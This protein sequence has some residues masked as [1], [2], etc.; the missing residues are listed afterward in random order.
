MVSRPKRPR[1]PN[2]LAKLIVD[3][4]TGEAVE[5]KSA[6]KPE[7]KKEP[8]GN[9]EPKEALKGKRKVFLNGRY[10]KTHIYDRDRLNPGA[11]IKGPAVIEQKDSTTLLFPGNAA[12]VDEYRNIIIKVNSEK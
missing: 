1:D 8:L 12:G 3:I 10:Y 2:Q 4:A 11:I 6:P 5:T 9:K 7:L